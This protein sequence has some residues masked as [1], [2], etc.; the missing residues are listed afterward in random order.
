MGAHQSVFSMNWFQ[1]RAERKRKEREE[2]L[3]A[4]LRADFKDRMFAALL[5]QQHRWASAYIYA[6]SYSRDFGPV[7]EANDIFAAM[8]SIYETLR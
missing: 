1:R 3:I 4:K 8:Y 2:A 6:A 7:T 5:L